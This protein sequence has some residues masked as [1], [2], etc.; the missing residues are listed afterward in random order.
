MK[1][2]YSFRR[3]YKKSN[4]AY[5]NKNLVYFTNE[6]SLGNQIAEEEEEEIKVIRS[7]KTYT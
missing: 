1:L 4:S 3:A 6:L 5:L 2:N 7:Y